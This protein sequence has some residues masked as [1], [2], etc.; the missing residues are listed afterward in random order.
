VPDY[1]YTASAAYIFKL[2]GN[3]SLVSRVDYTYSGSSYGSYQAYDYLNSPP[4]T[5]PNYRNPGYGVLNAS[6]GLTSTMLDVSLY[7]TNLANDRKIIQQP[8][9]NT[10]FEAYTVRPRTVGV[11]LKVRIQ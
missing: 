4:T 11:T 9:V 8:E 1:N 2:A 5:N 6:V 10:V 7:A 3:R